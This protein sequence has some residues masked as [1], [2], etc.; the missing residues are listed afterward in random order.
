MRSVLERLSSGAPDSEAI[1]LRCAACDT[2]ERISIDQFVHLA[3]WPECAV[4][5]TRKDVFVHRQ[6]RLDS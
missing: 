2:T 1:E 5:S 6:P 3:S 4:C